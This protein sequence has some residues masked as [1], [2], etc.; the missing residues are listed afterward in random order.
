MLTDRYKGNR[1]HMDLGVKTILRMW[2]L[3]KLF[4]NFTKVI[5]F[6]KTNLYIKLQQD[7]V[8]CDLPKGNLKEQVKNG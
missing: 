6:A 3:P 7:F 8:F 5:K 2:N 1:H 4:Y